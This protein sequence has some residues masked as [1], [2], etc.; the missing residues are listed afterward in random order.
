MTTNQEIFTTPSAPSPSAHRPI[1][2]LFDPALRE[3][4]YPTYR[5]LREHGPI[6]KVP[7]MDVWYFTRYAD[8]NAVLRDKRLGS[9]TRKAT[10]YQ[11]PG[12]NVRLPEHLREERSFMF[13]DPPDHTRLRGLVAGVFTPQMIYNMRPRIQQLVD[14]SLDAAEQRGTLEI[15]GEFSYP[16][17]FTVICEL[18]G[19]P[20]EH[21]EKF[22]A[23]SEILV[24]SM[25]P[26]LN[27]SPELVKQQTDAIVNASLFLNQM[28]DERR[29]NMGDD[30]LSALIRTEQNG[31]KLSQGELMSTVILLFGAGQETTVNLI[32]TAIHA[33]LT[34]PDELAKFRS[35]PGRAKQVVEET[36]RWDSPTQLVQRVALE[37]MEVAG[38]QIKRGDVLIVLIGSGNRD[39]ALVP[40]AE[41]FDIS[42]PQSPHLGFGHGPH[43]CLGAPLA[44][45]EGEIALSTIISRFPDI[46]LSPKGAVRRKT[47]VLR[48]F[49]A[50]HTEV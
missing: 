17:A 28:I 32:S 20:V 47:L 37:D 38:A 13:Q 49:S 45:A 29:R 3:D 27:P 43:F 18:V 2:N 16:L 42:R 11:K 34:H 9:D 44:R 24:G 36:I 19:L 30:L 7:G 1:F 25:D 35:D 33:L 41:R 23:W 4:P 21:R 5:A 39:D 6:G 26:E 14:Q 22:R 50:V 40:N 10:G 46:R 12:A 15:V 48:G 31:D 8:C